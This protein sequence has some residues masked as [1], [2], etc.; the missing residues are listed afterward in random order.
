MGGGDAPEVEETPEQKELARIAAEKWG[1]YQETYVPME[2]R[3]MERIDDMAS[4]W[5]GDFVAGAA[6]QSIQSEF[7]DAQKDIERRQFN[8]GV[9][10]N[11][12]RFDAATTGLSEARATE[13][14]KAETGARV[15]QEDAYITGLSN[16]VK[17]GQGQSIDAQQGLSE[18]AS[19]SAARANN[20]ARMEYEDH[21]S[22]RNMVGTAG[23]MAASYGLNQMNK[24]EE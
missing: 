2:N 21:A 10:P 5:Q 18:V 24:R 12:G 16:V 17:L 13:G 3:Y 1:K 15:E 19:N 9:N 11:S 8:T 14:A 23:G 22:T 7:S 20:A 6:N 4:E